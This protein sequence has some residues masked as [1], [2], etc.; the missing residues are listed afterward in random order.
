MSTTYDR[1]DLPILAE[2]WRAK[3]AREDPDIAGAAAS[4]GLD[5]FSDMPEVFW[6]LQKRGLIDAGLKQQGGGYLP[7]PTQRVLLTPTGLD[8]FEDRQG[9][10]AAATEAVERAIGK[11]RD[12]DPSIVVQAE[13][14]LARWAADVRNLATLAATVVLIAALSSSR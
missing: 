2:L 12:A 10:V 6:R 7:L 9:A 13:A 3:Q 8:D 11:R 4:I 1:E 5:Y 14:L